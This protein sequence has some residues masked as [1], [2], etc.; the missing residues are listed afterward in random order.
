MQACTLTEELPSNSPVAHLAMAL[1]F[2][3]GGGGDQR[4][5][6]GGNWQVNLFEKE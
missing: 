4:H 1:W 2:H 5:R 3:F 6:R